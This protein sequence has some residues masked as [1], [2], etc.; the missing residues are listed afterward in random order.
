[1]DA[2][3]MP[4]AHGSR[5]GIAA[6]SARPPL[7]EHRKHIEKDAALERLGSQTVL[8]ESA[9]GRGYDFHPARV[10]G[11][12]SR[13]TMAC[14]FRTTPRDQPPRFRTGTSASVFLPR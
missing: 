11:S 2:G 12:A 9:P 4:Q 1:M 14:A 13:C 7:D 3:D 8:V 10:C 5:A 6:A